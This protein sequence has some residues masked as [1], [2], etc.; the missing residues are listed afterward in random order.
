ML[1]V[2]HATPVMIRQGAGSIINTG[3][4][5]GLRTGFSAHGYSAAKAAVIHLSR[6]VAIELGK[7]GIRV[8]SISPGSIVTGIFGKAAGVSDKIADS[9]A[10]RLTARFAAFQ[11]TP[12][13]GMPDDIARVA[14]FL[15]SDA[16]SFVNG[17]DLLVDGGNVGGLP[18]SEMLAQRK[19]FAAELAERSGSDG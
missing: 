11:S 17:Q 2:K 6:C 3:S 1:G 5:A 14:L 10:S 13:A 8:N 15:A 19:A 9:T 7:K 18:W 16:S 12:R 4:V